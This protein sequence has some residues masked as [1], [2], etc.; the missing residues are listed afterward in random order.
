MIISHE[1]AHEGG[2]GGG[3]G[4]RGKGNAGDVRT[5]R[6]DEIGRDAG[7][8]FKRDPLFGPLCRAERVEEEAV[9]PPCVFVSDVDLGFDAE[10]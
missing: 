3:G 2:G 7:F 10:F 6:E 1:G 4:G 9:S 8:V 5:G